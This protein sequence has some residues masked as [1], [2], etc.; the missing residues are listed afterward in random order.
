MLIGQQIT[1]I[2][3]QMPMV[4]LSLQQVA[5]AERVQQHPNRLLL[6]LHR[7]QCQS[8]RARAKLLL[9][10]IQPLVV[11]QKSPTQTDHLFPTSVV[12][13]IPIQDGNAALKQHFMPIG[14]QIIT[15]SQ[16]MPTAEQTQLKMVGHLPAIKRHQL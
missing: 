4:V 10:G 8:Q 7:G 2:S 14:L 6:I 13:P 11:G 9:V 12:I 5:G 3:Q 1:I 15:P 16:Q